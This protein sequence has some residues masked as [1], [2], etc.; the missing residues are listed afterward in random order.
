MTE[1]RKPLKRTPLERR[2]PL[3]ARSTLK[4]KKKLQ[5]KKQLQPKKRINQRSKKQE[6][7][8]EKRRPFVAKMLADNPWCA[9]CPV[10]ADYD[11][12]V[13]YRRRQSS[14]VHE[15]VRRSQGGSIVDE[16]NCIAVC[17]P[18]HT[19]IGDNPQLAVDLGLAKRSWERDTPEPLD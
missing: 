8:Y 14:D 5:A 6:H 9:A 15:L 1:K 18:C 19:R 16:A 13:S 12:K 17:R 4:S 11:G 3:K 7:L 10:F 2:T